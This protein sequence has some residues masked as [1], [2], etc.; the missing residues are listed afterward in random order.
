[1]ILNFLFRKFSHKTQDMTFLE[2]VDVLRT[3]LIRSILAILLLS[4]LAF[5][6]KNIVFDIIVLG[7][8]NPDFIT[9]KAL[10]K[11]G[12]LTGINA[13][14]IDVLP[15]KLINIDLAGQFRY[16]LVISIITGIIL[17]SPFI[18]YQ[19][20]L[21]IKP[22]LTNKEL[23]Y[24]RGMVFYISSLFFIG[25]LFGY[26]IIVP[27]TVNFLATYELSA[28]IEN[29]ITIG[30]YI[31]IVAMLSL[32]MGLV[33][34]LPV[35][36]YFLSRIGMLTPK[37]LRK[38]RKHAIVVILIVAGFITPS[39]DMFSQVLVALPLYVLYEISIYISQRVEKK[40][41]AQVVE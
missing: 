3:Y 14:C 13:L 35:L 32:S 2:H 10:C 1:M 29:T 9:Y 36:I 8:K 23:G 39:T 34:E 15:F 33:F 6:F 37:F 31:S 26:F 38:Y 5:F 22:A 19:L 11:I 12:A 17:A 41:T 21:F 7:P 27:L 20:W 40:K 18:F 30:S 28:Q 16:H 24:A 4:I 25:V